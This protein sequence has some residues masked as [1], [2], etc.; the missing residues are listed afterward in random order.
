MI[1]QQA[2]TAPDNQISGMVDESVK[3]AKVFCKKNW[4]VFAFLDSHHPDIPEHPYPPHCIVGT[5]ETRLVPGTFFVFFYF[6]IQTIDVFSFFLF[7]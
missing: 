1:L 6:P 2:P 3:L 4:P 5:D 7:F